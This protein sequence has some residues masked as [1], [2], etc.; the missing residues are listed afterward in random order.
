[1]KIAF[2]IDDVITQSSKEII[3]YLEKNAHKEEIMSKMAVIMSG[4][5]EGEHINTF[6]KENLLE[7]YKTVELMDNVKEV[8]NRLISKGHEIYIV[9]ARGDECSGVKGSEELT[10]KFLKEK[11]IPYKQII[12]NAIDKAKICK[13]N[14]IQVLVDDSVKNCINAQERALRT[15]L[16][17]S[18]WNRNLNLGYMQRV[19]NWLE[20]EDKIEK[21]NAAMQ[22]L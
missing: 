17:N 12:F 18:E 1:M 2:D 7:I 10:L 4:N 22:V 13:E 15:I 16:F 14:K 6:F 8:L 19:D 20:L 21:L 9:T 5:L 3:K 11:E